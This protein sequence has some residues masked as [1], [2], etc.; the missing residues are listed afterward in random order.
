M[1][2]MRRVVSGP[3]VPVMSIFE[4]IGTCKHSFQG[5]PRVQ[6]QVLPAGG[7]LNITMWPGGA[8]WARAFTFPGHALFEHSLLHAL[9]LSPCRRR[10]S[11]GE[12][13]SYTAL[14]EEVSRNARCASPGGPARTVCLHNEMGP[15]T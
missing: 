4:S 3:Y 5:F 2:R 8:A 11:T 1:V 6:W 7:L 9:Q 12:D 13:V 14:L 15:R 10:L